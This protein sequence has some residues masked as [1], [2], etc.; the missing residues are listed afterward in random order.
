MTLA[1]RTRLAVTWSL[2]LAA[3]TGYLFLGANPASADGGLVI[4]ALATLAYKVYKLHK[5]GCG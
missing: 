3:V 1:R 4:I 2:L 5:C